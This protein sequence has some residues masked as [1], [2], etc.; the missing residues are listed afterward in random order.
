MLNN[1]FKK[2]FDIEK[3]A[4]KKMAIKRD[5]SEFMN[6]LDSIQNTAFIGTPVSYT[7][8]DVYK[9]QML[10]VTAE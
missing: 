1:E 8:R 5:F 9:R 3:E 4:P 7:H 2:K 10:I 6:K